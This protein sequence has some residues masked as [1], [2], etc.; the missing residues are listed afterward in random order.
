MTTE[1][2]RQELRERIEAGE[3][4]NAVRSELA[5]KALEARDQAVGFAKQHPVAVV[6]GGVA[7]GLL[8][9]ALTPK[10]RLLGKRAG[11]WVAMLAEVGAV[12]AADILTK[13]GDVAET[14]IDKIGDIGGT[15]GTAARSAGREIES[16]AASAGGSARSIGKRL[17]RKAGDAVGS[18]KDRITH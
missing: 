2:R 7:L 3:E 12:Y 15:V 8:V 10:G 16:R 14:G 18:L 9:G 13:A 4:R 5:A 1:T 17:T 6:A 11:K